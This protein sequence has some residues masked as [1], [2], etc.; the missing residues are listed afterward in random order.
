MQPI[1]SNV[2]SDL[3]SLCLFAIVNKSVRVIDE[4]A[5]K[6]KQWAMV[7]VIG[8]VFTMLPVWAERWV[9]IRNYTGEV[10][11]RIDRD[12][13]HKDP[14]DGLV[15]YR[16]QQMSNP[17]EEAE[18]AVDCQRDLYYT[19]KRGDTNYKA[20]FGQSWYE[21]GLPPSTVSV[22]SSAA[23]TQKSILCSTS[24]Q[25]VEGEP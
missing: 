22:L 9:D 14:E 19:V 21:K 18:D 3:E 2:P 10:V 25:P 12:S 23:A 7:A 24:S 4:E 20:V 8:I 11:T 16:L 5:I 13:I 6:V 17:Q 15:Y 1:T